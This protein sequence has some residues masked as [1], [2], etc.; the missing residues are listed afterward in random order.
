MSKWTR[1][2]IVRDILRREAAGL[3]LTSARVEHGVEPAMYQAATRIF[4]SWRNAIVAAGMP[5]SRAR[6]N[7]EWTPA[8]IRKVIR[9]LSRRRQPLG[10]N[11]L[12]ERYGNFLQAARR[13]FGSWSKAI[14]A[15]GVD[16]QRMQRCPTWSKERVIEGILMLA[17]RNEPLQRR[18]VQSRSLVDAGS[19]VF[20]S[21]RAALT[22]A[23]VGPTSLMGGVPIE[24]KEDDPMASNS[25]ITTSAVLPHLPHTQWSDRQILD[26][27]IQRVRDKQPVYATVVYNEYRSLYRAATRRF[28]NWKCTLMAAGLNPSECRKSAVS[29]LNP[30]V[31]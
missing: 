20:G 13:H 5:A 12:E 17:L 7:S 9:S 22:A 24:T 26:A 3:P 6:I 30:P 25:P 19:R 23:G 18:F 14:I 10:T 11:E 29:A 2:R 4:G 31:K 1:E 21:W 27:V 8:R 28:G 15:A 16:P